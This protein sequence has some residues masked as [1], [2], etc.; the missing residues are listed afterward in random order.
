MPNIAISAPPVVTAA[1]GAGAAS[2]TNAAA[3]E[4]GAAAAS[5]ADLLQGQLGDQVAAGLMSE[6]NADAILAAATDSLAG[7]DLQDLLPQLLGAKKLATGET[8]ETGHGK[9]DAEDAETSPDL[10]LAAPITAAVL[11]TATAADTAATAATASSTATTTA[12]LA[13][14]AELAAGSQNP[15]AGDGDVDAFAR[16]LSQETQDTV[17][18]TVT[19]STTVHS[20]AAQQTSGQSATVTA[21]VGTQTWNNQVGEQLVWMAGKQESRAELVLTPPQ[22]GRIEVSLSVSGDQTNAV[23]VSS[24]PAV[25]EALESALPRLREILADAGIN[26]GQAQVSS[27]SPNQSANQQESGDNRQSARADDSFGVETAGVTTTTRAA[28]PWTSTGR[29]LVDVFA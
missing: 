15:T 21:T 22:L 13:A 17:T 19:A 11:P 26:L 28:N 1:A 25:R 24:N 12:N 9:T 18:P 14:K 3:S 23:F 2:G 20:A 29:G 10:L 6:E 27:E 8:T 4:D 7:I 16:L 5:F